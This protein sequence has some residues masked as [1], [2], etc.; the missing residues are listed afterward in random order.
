[1]GI[2]LC[3]M[4]RHRVATAMAPRTFAS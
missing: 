2:R 1:L 3:T 4:V